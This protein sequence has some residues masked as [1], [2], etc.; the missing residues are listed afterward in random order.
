MK[1][2]IEPKTSIFRLSNESLLSTEHS[3]KAALLP[4]RLEDLKNQISAKLFLGDL[5][6]P[7]DFSKYLELQESLGRSVIG[8]YLNSGNFMDLDEFY[9]ISFEKMEFSR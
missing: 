3:Q 4:K 9:E 7:P 8:L 2:K 6:S 1:G 5:S